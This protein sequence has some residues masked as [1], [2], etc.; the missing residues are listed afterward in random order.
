MPPRRL[1]LLFALLACAALHPGL[2]RAAPAALKSP[3]RASDAVP[4]PLR[5]W[6]GWAL[7]G[8][9]DERCILLHDVRTCVF[10]TALALAVE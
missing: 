7:H 5:P 10:P 1:R 4:D 3:P 8:S 9:E 2:A 6:I